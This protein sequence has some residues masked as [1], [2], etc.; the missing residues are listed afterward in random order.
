M[1]GEDCAP[2]RSSRTGDKPG[3]SRHLVRWIEVT[4]IA[5]LQC[6]EP[7]HA[8]P[9]RRVEWRQRTEHAR[10]CV[11]ALHEGKEDELE[12]LR[13]AL[14]GASFHAGDCAGRFI[15]DKGEKL[16]NVA[17]GFLTP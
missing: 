2:R 14:A 4:N 12:I 9:E 3:R 15:S 13:P 8:K 1:H 10:M 5:Q 6:A 7:R 11:A 17:A 16:R